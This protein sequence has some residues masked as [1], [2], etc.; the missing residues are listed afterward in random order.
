MET[1]KKVVH[2]HIEDRLEHQMIE[3]KNWNL[4]LTNMVIV[5]SQ[6]AHQGNQLS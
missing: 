6:Q 1:T 2:A 5:F 3:L 4:N